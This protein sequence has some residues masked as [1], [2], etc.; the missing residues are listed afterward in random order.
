MTGTPSGGETALDAWSRN[1][2]SRGSRSTIAGRLQ[3]SANGRRSPLGP[4]G[5]PIKGA[6]FQAAAMAKTL[7]SIVIPVHNKAVLTRQCL[8]SIIEARPDVP[9]EVIVVDDAS[10]DSTPTMLA[11]YGE[12]V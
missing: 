9:F 8:D 1:R 2:S 4:L 3:C 7:F 12:E 10:R 5:E 11:G 6:T